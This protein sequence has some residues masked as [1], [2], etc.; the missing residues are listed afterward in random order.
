MALERWPKSQANDTGPLIHTKWLLKAKKTIAVAI[1]KISCCD[2]QIPAVLSATS[3]QS[4]YLITPFSEQL[5]HLLWW[6]DR[7]LDLNDIP[8]SQPKARNCLQLKNIPYHLLWD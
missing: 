4:M 8:N 6:H 2:F 3:E 5:S 1:K 7:C